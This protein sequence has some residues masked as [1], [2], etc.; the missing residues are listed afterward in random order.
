MHA[1]RCVHRIGKKHGPKR[2]KTLS[3]GTRIDECAPRM[4]EVGV[5]KMVL[6]KINT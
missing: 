4:F 2:E 5:I 3:V 6:E 1:R